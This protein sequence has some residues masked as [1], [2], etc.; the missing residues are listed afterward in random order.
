MGTKDHSD[1]QYFNPFDVMT[2]FIGT[3]TGALI[4]L[5]SLTP[6]SWFRN[7]FPD[8]LVVAFLNMS[9]G[10]RIYLL[11]CGM[12][13]GLSA[14]ASLMS[15]DPDVGLFHFRFW[16]EVFANKDN[17]VLPA[18][19]ISTFLLMTWSS[20]IILYLSV[21]PMIIL[22]S[23]PLAIIVSY[24]MVWRNPTITKTIRAAIYLALVAISYSFFAALGVNFLEDKGFTLLHAATYT[25]T[26]AIP[27]F[28][29]S[30]GLDVNAQDSKG[31]TPLH[32]AVVANRVGMV[33]ALIRAGA[34]VNRTDHQQI[35]PLYWACKNGYIEI[36]RM[37]IQANPA[38]LTKQDE[39]YLRLLAQAAIEGHRDTVKLL[40]QISQNP[41]ESSTEVLF[42]AVYSGW[43][44][45]TQVLLEAGAD[46]RVIPLKDPEISPK[47]RQLLQQFQERD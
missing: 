1:Y 47:I 34:D 18:I 29:I 37:L 32:Y 39:K 25:R 2:I 7:S 31:M 15:R 26:P 46:V 3:S 16:R 36:V 17:Q 45:V 42:S 13:G 14:L 33:K 35:T 43:F 22:H 11:A 4:G 44:G 38:V 23:L 27:K 20:L 30:Q 10:F 5:I 6:I 21:E 19:L 41:K 28:L 9:L 8:P 40:L 24:A 12:I